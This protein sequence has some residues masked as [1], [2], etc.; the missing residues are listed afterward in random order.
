[1]F[2]Y[3]Y[4]IITQ[5]KKNIWQLFAPLKST[6]ISAILNKLRSSRASHRSDSEQKEAVA[7]DKTWKKRMFF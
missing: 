1:M 3:V 2:F 6:K 4:K 5:E 7:L